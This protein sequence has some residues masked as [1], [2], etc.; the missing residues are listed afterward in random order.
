[1][2]GGS[3]W[4]PVKI[5]NNTIESVVNTGSDI[6]EPVGDAAADVVGGVT[7]LVKEGVV[8]SVTFVWRNEARM[9]KAL[10]IE[11]DNLFGSELL[12][13]LKIGE[14]NQDLF[15]DHPEETMIV[16]ATV[17]SFGLATGLMPIYLNLS[18]MGVYASANISLE[19]AILSSFVQAGAYAALLEREWDTYIK[20]MNRYALKKNEQHANLLSSTNWYDWLPGGFFYNNVESGGMFY[21]IPPINKFEIGLGV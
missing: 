12:G 1:M 15:Y 18:F 8:D 10:G 16:G 19:L 13:N 21:K 4:N 3:S 14:W 2:G 5:V 6:L 20:E 11:E 7:H 17:L 9:F